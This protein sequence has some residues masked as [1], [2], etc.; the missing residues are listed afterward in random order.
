MAS[1]KEEEDKDFK[2][3]V[4]EQD[5]MWPNLHRNFS[6]HPTSEEISLYGKGR[7]GW[8]ITSLHQF[9]VIQ[10]RRQ[11]KLL[12]KIFRRPATTLFAVLLNKK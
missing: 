10:L 8:G 9:D 3:S 11:L 7:A 4:Y 1:L 5:L 12:P 2:E 6:E